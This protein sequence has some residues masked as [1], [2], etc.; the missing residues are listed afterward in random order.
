[1]AQ[2]K[3][4]QGLVFFLYPAEMHRSVLGPWQLASPIKE[5]GNIWVFQIFLCNGSSE[6]LLEGMI[7]FIIIIIF[8]IFLG[9]HLQHMEVHRLGVE[10]EL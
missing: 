4:C 5:L 3:A 1:M 8:F 2:I 10:L 6:T 9:P 7:L